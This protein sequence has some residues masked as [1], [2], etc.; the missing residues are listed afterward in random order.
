MYPSTRITLFPITE[1]TPYINRLVLH[2]ND[3][4]VRRFKTV[5]FEVFWQIALDLNRLLLVTY[6]LAVSI[7]ARESP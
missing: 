6:F 1:I 3:G 4:H 7:I 2:E 5:S